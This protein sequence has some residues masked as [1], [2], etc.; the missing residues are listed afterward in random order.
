MNENWVT[1]INTEKKEAQPDINFCFD[2]DINL[3]NVNINICISIFLI[4]VPS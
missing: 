2:I 1:L 3:A 4:M